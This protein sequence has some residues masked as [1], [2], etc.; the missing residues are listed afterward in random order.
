[1]PAP[2]FTSADVDMTQGS[3]GKKAYDNYAS[4]AAAN[5]ATSVAGELTWQAVSQAFLLAAGYAKQFDLA[6][7]Q[8][9][10]AD[11]QRD[12]VGRNMALA[13]KNYSEMALP[14][15]KQAEAYFHQF[16]RKSW[17]PK[18]LEIA[19]CGLKDCEYEPD[20]NRWVTRGI[21]DVAKVVNG[22]KIAARRNMDVYSAGLCCDLDYRFAE[23]QSKLTVD[24]INIGRVYEDDRKAKLDQFYWN[25]FT[26][27]G[28]MI[29]NIGTLAANINQFGKGAVN[30]ALSLQTQAVAGFDRAVESGMEAL[31]NQSGLISSLGGLIGGNSGRAY[32]QSI[33]SLILGNGAQ[34]PITQ[35]KFGPVDTSYTDN[36]S[37]SESVM[38]SFS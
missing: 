12:A 18:L 25:K 35:P 38:Q 11:A 22:A 33:G 10:L 36:T 3:I 9:D 17:E 19:K 4:N 6:E 20:Y 1:M 31:K 30:Q 23:L 15:Y 26:T 7:K 27:V 29:Q 37:S 24:T 21:V 5:T 13:E 34:S 28:G 2:Y 16:Y 14:A 8:G 32:G